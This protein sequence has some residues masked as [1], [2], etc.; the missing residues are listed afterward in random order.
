MSDDKK[1]REEQSEALAPESRALNGLLQ[2]FGEHGS[3]QHRELISRIMVEARKDITENEVIKLKPRPLSTLLLKYFLPAAACLAIVG[4]LFLKL[5]P[6]H[7][8]TQSSIDSAFLMTTTPSGIL[9][10]HGKLMAISNGMKIVES[11]NIKTHAT[12]VAYLQFNDLSRLEL[13]GNSVLNYTGTTSVR[14]PDHSRIKKIAIQLTS[15]AIYGDILKT[16]GYGLFTINTPQGK[17]KINYG[18]F[19]L[20][21]RD[22]AFYLEVI[23]GAV[24]FKA[25]N[26][27]QVLKLEPGQVCLLQSDAKFKIATL[28]QLKPDELL[29][30][31]T[32]GCQRLTLDATGFEKLLLKLYK[33][34]KADICFKRNH[35]R[36]QR[37]FL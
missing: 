21:V 6:Q 19:I 37:I 26:Q 11:D 30:Q 22:D 27:A 14:Q 2:E 33:K 29:A 5:A 35:R 31:A 24:Q 23:S 34:R 9:K 8:K 17:L 25:K 3:K 4:G 13:S 1:Y 7:N 32:S 16:S 10:R 12:T 18:K 20:G 36:K 28:K 15:G